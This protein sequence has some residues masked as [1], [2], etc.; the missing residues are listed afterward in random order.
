MG[1]RLISLILPK[2]ARSGLEAVIELDKPII[3]PLDKNAEVG[4]IVLSLQGIGIGTYPLVTLSAINLGSCASR[5][6][7]EIRLQLR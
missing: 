2:G 6:F 5:I 1:F 3:A 7:D 4:T